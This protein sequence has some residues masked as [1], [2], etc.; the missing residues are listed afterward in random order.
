MPRYRYEALTLEGERVS[1]RIR[2]ATLPDAQLELERHGMAITSIN[3][4]RSRASVELRAARIPPT[5]LMHLSRQLGAFVRAGIPIT[6]AMSDLSEGSEN[7]AVRAALDAIAEDLRSGMTL[8][9]AF[10]AHPRDFPP[11]Y[12]GILRSAELTGNLCDVL[13]Q[14]AV[15][16][17]R[18]LEARRKVRT[19]MMYPAIVAVMAVLTSVILA[20]FVL[21]R[22]EVFF[23]SLDAQLPLPTR[24][25]LAINDF[26]QRWLW[27][28]VGAM[29]TLV[30]GFVVGVRTRAGRR[31][32]DRAVLR[33]P[34]IGPT[35]R[36]AV[37]ER[38]TRVLASMVH[39]GIPLPVAMDVATSSLHNL[40]FEE[41]LAV[42]RAQM[43]DGAGLAGPISETEMFPPMAVQM[44][45]VGEQ[46]GTLDRQLD[47]AAGFYGRELDHQVKKLSAL[48][49]PA[50]IL[51]MGGLVGFVAVALVSAMYGIFRA[52]PLV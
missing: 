32:R 34:V 33:I 40:A 11:F 47:M 6:Q 20:F 9:D 44:M 39:G 35:M 37:T 50:I 46:T 10:G 29:V 16:I 12:I 24:I 23:A 15:Y 38:F 31:M 52:T 18:D 48:V 30:V 49:E 19:A 8:S 42:A 7:R 41:P 25:L 45:R 2:A 1:G 17:E 28:I 5:E 14:L 22:F 26:V 43:L 4:G 27:V 13:D 36:S 3:A 51:V 21:P